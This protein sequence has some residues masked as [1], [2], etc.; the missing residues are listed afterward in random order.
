MSSS[1]PTPTTQGNPLSSLTKLSPCAY[2]Y[3]PSTTTTTTTT[4]PSSDPKLIILS[5]WM[6]AAPPHIAKYLIPYQDLYPSSPILLLRSS[7]RHFL[8]P[9][10]AAHELKPAVTYFRSVFPSP[11]SNNN[12]NNNN[13][14]K[15]ELLIHT[16]SN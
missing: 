8:L 7:A 6:S 14:N 15:P 4:P 10:L 1:T 16:F 11:T 2:I 9:Y 5:T 12:N 13:N 3:Q